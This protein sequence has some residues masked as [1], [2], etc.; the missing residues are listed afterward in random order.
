MPGHH[1]QLGWRQQLTDLQWQ[2]RTRE[3]H[4]LPHRLNQ[5]TS[6]IGSSPETARSAC[7]TRQIRLTTPTRLRLAANGTP[8]ARQ[9]WDNRA[10]PALGCPPFKEFMMNVVVRRTSAM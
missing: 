8:F 4:G 5:T 2:R 1:D 10:T 3:P 6:P 7:S 9:L